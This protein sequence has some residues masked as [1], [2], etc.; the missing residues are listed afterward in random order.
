MSSES[1]VSQSEAYPEA[2]YPDEYA[3]RVALPRV[4]FFE[5]AVDVARRMKAEDVAASC[6]RCSG[7][8]CGPPKGD[9][10][11]ERS[12]LMADAILLERA[13]AALRRRLPPDLNVAELS[14]LS[15]IQRI[16]GDWREQAEAPD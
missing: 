9:A 10:A 2:E 12:K 11:I 7:P 13:A 1:P 6:P 4:A 14:M 5:D 16:A 8:M 15:G 3:R